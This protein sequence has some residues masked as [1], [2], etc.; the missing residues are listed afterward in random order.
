MGK[1]RLPRKIKKKLRGHIWLYPADEKGN[2][3]MAWPHE[4]SKDYAALKKGLVSEIIDRKNSKT[5][6]KEYREKLDKVK[7]V[8]D[9]ELKMFVEEIFAEQYRRSSFDILISAKNNPKAIVAYY[10][11]I[12]AWYLYKNGEESF[13]NICCMAVD[14]AK[15]LLKQR[16]I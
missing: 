6:G 1:F 2:R 5:R 12:N 9:E 7:M 13:A 14:L 3:L 10:N 16:R 11:F 8:A 4:S 15:K